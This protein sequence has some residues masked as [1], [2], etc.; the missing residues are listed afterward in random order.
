VDLVQCGRFPGV[1]YL[2]PEP[3]AGFRSLTG[4]VAAQWPEAP[5]YGGRFADVVPQLTIAHSQD[6]EALDLL[7]SEVR[8]RLPI[9]ARIE[10]VQLMA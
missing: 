4:A 9:S 8:A 7:E 1:L 3:D 10:S 5:P 2:A 6:D